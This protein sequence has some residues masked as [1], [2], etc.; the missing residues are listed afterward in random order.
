MSSNIYKQKKHI[1][2]LTSLTSDATHVLKDH[3]YKSVGKMKEF[4]RLEYLV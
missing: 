4:V 3:S 1:L 2:K